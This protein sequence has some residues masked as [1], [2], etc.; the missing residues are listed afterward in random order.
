MSTRIIASVS[1][2]QRHG[3]FLDMDVSADVTKVEAGGTV[4]LDGPVRNQR[5]VAATMIDAMGTSAAT[6]ETRAVS[7]MFDPVTG[8]MA[9]TETTP[10]T[11]TWVYL[12]DTAVE[13]AAMASAVPSA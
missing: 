11:V 13:V 4:A 1:R 10:G 2:V 6:G 7:K 5:R 12:R 3:K 9:Y 8:I